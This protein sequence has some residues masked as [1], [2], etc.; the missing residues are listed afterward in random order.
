LK[1]AFPNVN[2]IGLK[3]N[4]GFARANNVGIRYALKNGAD[5][6]FLLNNDAVVEPKTID[7]LLAA[8]AQD[9]KIGIVGA[10]ILDSSSP[11]VIDNMGAKI[12]FYTGYSEFLAHGSIYRE[13]AEL[14]DVDYAS[15]AAM[16]IKK[17]V[18]EKIGLLPE[19]YFL[20][21]EEKDYCISASEK[22]F[23][24]VCAPKAKVIHKISSTV[25][26]YPGIKNY[27]F[28]RNR[29]IFLRLHA[30]THQFVFAILYSCLWIFPYYIIKYLIRGRSKFHNGMCELANFVQGVF[31]GV[32]FKTGCTKKVG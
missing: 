18:I 32:N 11:M 1:S 25:K 9:S 22:G 14:K 4:F 20:Y 17:E 27:Y 28:H 30:R 16:M 12:N 26:K 13:N 7:N 3:C 19:F 24:I 8:Y 21:G 31:D 23:R 10:T 15:G 29:F 5:F 6:V 2:F